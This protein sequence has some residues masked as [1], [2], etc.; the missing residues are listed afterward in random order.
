MKKLFKYRGRSFMTALIMVV[1]AL[2]LGPVL[3]MAGPSDTVVI[4]PKSADPCNNPSAIK[5]SA[6]ISAATGTTNLVSLTSA[7]SVYIC[8]VA[9]YLQGTT[10]DFQLVT[11]LTS[12]CLTSPVTLTGVIKPLTGTGITLGFGGTV[13]KGSSGGAICAVMSAATTTATGII[14]YV[15]Q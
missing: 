7:K 15:K 1:V 8:H 2:M 13:T 14:T 6:V 4:Y 12:T 11:G 10:P 3:V 5:S 9:S